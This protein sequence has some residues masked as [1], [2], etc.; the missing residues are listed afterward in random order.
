MGIKRCQFDPK[1]VDFRVIG[2]GHKPTVEY[3]RTARDVGDCRSHHAAGAAFSGSYDCASFA[4]CME[5][6][7]SLGQTAS[8]W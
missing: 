5:K 6:L 8:Q 1:H 2:V 3:G 4:S 7:F